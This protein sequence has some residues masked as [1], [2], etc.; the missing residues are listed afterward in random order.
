MKNNNVGYSKISLTVED[1][2]I[3][4][5]E[6]NYLEKRLRRALDILEQ[7]DAYLEPQDAKKIR[8]VMEILKGDEKDEEIQDN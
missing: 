1:Y 3:L 2:V 8:K 6:R 4:L 5:K 7:F